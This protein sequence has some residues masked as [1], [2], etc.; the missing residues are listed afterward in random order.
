[1][2]YEVLPVHRKLQSSPRH[3]QIPLLPVPVNTVYGLDWEAVELR[4]H[5][6]EQEDPMQVES[7]SLP[8]IYD[9]H[10]SPLQVAL[11]LLPAMELVHLAREQKVI[12][13]LPAHRL[14]PLSLTEQT[15]CGRCG[16]CRRCAAIG[17]RIL[18]RAAAQAESAPSDTDTLV[19]C[20][21]F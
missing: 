19:A 9:L 1:M 5:R 21:T 8:V 20:V 12:Q 13:P 10:R 18:N 2:P 11:A 15:S 4:L 6:A 14:L 17:H 7:P 3:M 16:P